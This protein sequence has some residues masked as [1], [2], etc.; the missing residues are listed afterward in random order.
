MSDVEN[1]VRQVAP[2]H[3]FVVSYHRIAPRKRP[4]LQVSGTP[5]VEYSGAVWT[6][7]QNQLHFPKLCLLNV[8][9]IGE[10]NSQRTDETVVQVAGGRKTFLVLV[11][12]EKHCANC[13]QLHHV[14]NLEAAPGYIR[15]LQAGCG[16]MTNG[17]ALRS[18]ILVPKRRVTLPPEGILESPGPAQPIWHIFLCG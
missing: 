10:N 7:D 8:S 1:C 6:C 15:V 4:V 3:Y 5:W 12:V 14:R 16:S 18:D 17:M 9:N 13:G 2:K 11:A